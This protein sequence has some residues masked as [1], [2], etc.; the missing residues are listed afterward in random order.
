[1]IRARTPDHRPINHLSSMAGSAAEIPEITP[2]RRES[3]RE[4]CLQLRGG[5]NEQ[6]ANLVQARTRHPVGGAGDREYRDRPGAGLTG[7]GRYGVKAE[8][9]LL[10]LG[11][12]SALA[13]G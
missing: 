1:M 9:E 3:S 8:L 4:C 11:P 6:R 2:G 5:P 13:Q 10:D 12:V 7:G